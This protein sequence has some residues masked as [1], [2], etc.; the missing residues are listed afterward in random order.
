MSNLLSPELI[1]ATIEAKNFENYMR[2]Q[3]GINMAI[4]SP[5][6]PSST[7]P[8]TDEEIAKIKADIEKEIKAKWDYVEQLKGCVK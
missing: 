8:K 6:A 7:P 3:G 2:K 5:F 1:Y 4:T